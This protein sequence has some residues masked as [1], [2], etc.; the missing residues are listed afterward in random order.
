M[1]TFEQEDIPCE[2]IIQELEKIKKGGKHVV[3]MG[4]GTAKIAQHFSKDPRFQ[5]TS[6]DHVAI[7]D[8]VQVCDISHMPLEDGSVDICIMS[9]ALWGSNCDEYIREA[10]RVLDENGIL[11]IIDSTKRWSEDGCL[12]AGKLKL[13]LETNGFQIKAKDTRIDKWCYFKCMK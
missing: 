12:A 10:L 9:L 4:C 13:L 2:R 7:N 5:I 3:D 11:Y 8:T 1:S 6:Y